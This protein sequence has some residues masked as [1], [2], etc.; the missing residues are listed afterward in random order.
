MRVGVFGDF[1][2]DT[3]EDEEM[4][5]YGIVG[6]HGLVEECQYFLNSELR[7]PHEAISLQS[8]D[9]PSLLISS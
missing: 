3:G 9:S 1:G 6:W 8:N 4:A 7:G 5:E 2:Q